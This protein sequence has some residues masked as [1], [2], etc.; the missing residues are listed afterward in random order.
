MSSHTRP[1]KP[2]QLWK[3]FFSCMNTVY[4]DFAEPTIFWFLD[5]ATSCITES[6]R[7]T[8]GFAYLQ[9]IHQ[10]H[11]WHWIFTLFCVFCF[12]FL[13]K[14]LN[15][16]LRLFFLFDI[17]P[18]GTWHLTDT[19]NKLKDTTPNRN[20]PPEHDCNIHSNIW[21]QNKKTPQ[22]NYYNI[23]YDHLFHY[24][25]NTEGFTGY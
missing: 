14:R 21:I 18:A 4:D 24:Q 22:N 15:S 6:S 20:S 25:S 1:L 12:F 8:S 9:P 16:I 13:K 19:G 11:K 7:I 5:T 10:L 17:E 3:T 23:K 2:F